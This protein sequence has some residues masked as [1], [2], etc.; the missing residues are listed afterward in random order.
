[1]E[2]SVQ[3]DEHNIRIIVDD[4]GLWCVWNTRGKIKTYTF[5]GKTGDYEEFIN[6][7]M[8]LAATG[9]DPE[10]NKVQ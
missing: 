5:I 1:M 7:I 4:T 8:T 10:D 6:R 3:K 2:N 9:L